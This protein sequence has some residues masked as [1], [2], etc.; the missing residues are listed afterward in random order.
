MKVDTVEDD[1]EIQSASLSDDGLKQENIIDEPNPDT[2]P[3]MIPLSFDDS[4][5]RKQ[6]IT[7]QK[8]ALNEPEDHEDTICF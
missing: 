4:W 5:K 1:D 6:L 7:L 3:N 8:Q 2:N